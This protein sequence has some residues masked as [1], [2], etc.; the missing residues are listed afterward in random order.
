MV[1]IFFLNEAQSDLSLPEFLDEKSFCLVKD[2]SDADFILTPE[3]ESGCYHSEKHAISNGKYHA[4]YKAL[5]KL[6]LYNSFK[7]MGFDGIPTVRVTSS[8]DIENFPYER[9]FL[10]PNVYTGGFISESEY[11]YKPITKEAAISYLPNHNTGDGLVVQPCFMNEDNE[12]E[13][14]IITGVV[15][16]SGSIHFTKSIESKHRA[17]DGII[18]AVRGNV[19]YEL[20]EKA[21]ELTSKYI[22]Y[23]KI[24]NTVFSL[25]F[26]KVEGKILPMDFQYRLNYWERHVIPK[27]FTDYTK[28]L[29]KY[30]F[31]VIS[32]VPADPTAMLSFQLIEIPADKDAT[33]VKNLMNEM[34]NIYI[35]SLKKR[36]DRNRL[37]Y[38]ISSDYETMQKNILFFKGKLC[39]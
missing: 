23:Q 12:T 25:Q 22:E 33:F 3:F 17:V 2:I 32:G 13:L 21:R 36:N 11:L 31:D 27:R 15:N 4:P 14:L 34:G 1:N 5:R 30:A 7:E 20:D 37:F 26:L 28:N 19:S 18:Y 8:S 10:K 24:K 9:L 29:Y 35:Y 38:F 16:S 6:D 39:E